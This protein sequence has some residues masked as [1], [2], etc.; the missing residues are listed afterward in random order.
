M[1]TI[2]AIA[3]TT[4]AAADAARLEHALVILAGVRAALVRVMQEAR[5]GPAALK[6]GLEGPQRQL[7][8]VDGTHGPGDDE[9]GVQ[10]GL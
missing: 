1:L 4:H 5:C 7:P 3:A 6:R 8:V 9:A 10:V 2:V